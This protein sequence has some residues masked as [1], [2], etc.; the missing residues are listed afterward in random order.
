MTAPS[1]R[2]QTLS[3]LRLLKEQGVARVPASPKAAAIRAQTAAKKRR[4]AA[5]PRPPTRSPAPAPF[6]PMT[7]TLQ[8]SPD[9][10][11]PP[12]L[13]ENPPGAT[14]DTIA[15]EILSCRSCP[16][17]P[18][19]TRY[20]PGAG[21]GDAPDIMFVGEGPGADEDAQG[22]PFVGRSG[23]LLTKMINAMGYDRSAVFLGN[24][25]KCRPPG[26]RTPEPGEMAACIPYLR[27]QIALIRPKL[28][29][30]L[31]ATAMRGL[32]GLKGSLTASRGQWYDFEGIPVMVTFHPAYLLRD[33]S[34]KKYAWTDLKLVLARLGRT[35]PSP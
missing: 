29:V 18:P 27:R 15:A 11:R 6:S 35:P 34:K 5:P 16:L 8:L 14:L 10:P 28:L 23:Q 31:G 21:N 2:D 9:E 20:V 26:N 25:V 3:Y 24:I 4:P 33:P 32:L 7:S 19:P 13:A 1:L 30:C 22:L 12:V 17:G